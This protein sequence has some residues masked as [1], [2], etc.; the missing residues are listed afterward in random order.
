M[1]S[2]IVAAAILLYLAAP[3]KA[4]ADSTDEAYLQALHS[5][6]MYDP[7]AGDSELVQVGHQMCQ[8]LIGGMTDEELFQQMLPAAKH[9]NPA[10][11]RFLIATA[12]RYYCPA[13]AGVTV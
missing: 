13:A 5:Y 4:S 8:L 7:A 6:G 9:I 12:R 3:A 1:R 10:D 11:L 2:A